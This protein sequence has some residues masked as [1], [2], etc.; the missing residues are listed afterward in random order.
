LIKQTRKLSLGNKVLLFKTI[1]V[2]SMTYCIQ[3][4]GN[5]NVLKV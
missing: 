2:P 4:C 5:S 1:V 3:L